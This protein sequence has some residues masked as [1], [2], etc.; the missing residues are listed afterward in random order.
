MHSTDPSAPV[1]ALITAPDPESAARVARGLVD[2]GLA[3]C[4]NLVPGL[5]SIFR[6]KG[7]VEQADE[8]L[9]IVKTT[10]GRMRDCE[11]ALAALHPYEVPEF[12]AFE[13][14]HVAAAYRRWLGDECR[15][16]SAS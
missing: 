8:I 11:R 6:W 3:A 10:A 7:Q 14:A 15:G 12:I 2:P 1:V 13:P 5:T 4:V 9:L 16:T